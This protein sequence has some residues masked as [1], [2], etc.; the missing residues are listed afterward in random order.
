MW[1]NGHPLVV[2]FVKTTTYLVC[3]KLT[4]VLNVVHDDKLIKRLGCKMTKLIGVY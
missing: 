3:Q 1:K 4:N 2:M